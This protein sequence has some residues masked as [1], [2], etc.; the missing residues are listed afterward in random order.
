M[1]IHVV[2]YLTHFS[3]SRHKIININ[4]M[5]YT[6]A[7]T[8]LES[9]VRLGM[10]ARCFEQS[11]KGAPSQFKEGILILIHHLPCM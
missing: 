11:L 10:S 3:D 2:K 9:S 4:R 8:S 5:T 7:Q 6:M 1:Y